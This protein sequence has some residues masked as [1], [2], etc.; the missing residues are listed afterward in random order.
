[1][2]I[3]QLI[4]RGESKTL[5]FKRDASSLLPII[6][7][8]IAFANT[9]GGILLIGATDEHLLVNVPEPDKVRDRIFSSVGDSIHPQLHVNIEKISIK[10]KI[11]LAITVEKGRT[12]YHLKSEGL[13][14]GTYVR[15][16]VLSQILI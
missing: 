3:A 8:L 13:E 11:L 5:E 15:I 12:P 10:D 7:T 14:Q 1:M 2:N 16:G 9:A 6:K 4:E